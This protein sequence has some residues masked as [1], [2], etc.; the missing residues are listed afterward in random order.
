MSDFSFVRRVKM[1]QARPI[2]AQLG[3]LDIELTERC[4]NDCIHCCINLPANDA[5][6]KARE[7]STTVLKDILFQAA[8]LGCL[9]VRFTGGEPLL[10]RDFRELYLCAR[11]LGMKVLLFTNA[12]AG[13]S[14]Y[15]QAV[16]TNP[17]AGAH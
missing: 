4:N 15:R 17:A 16:C 12:L 10:R 13:H 2:K 1:H 6:A 3:S 14:A 9:Q 5:G 7:T 8:E 11:K